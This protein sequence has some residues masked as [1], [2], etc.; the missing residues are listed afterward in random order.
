[1]RRLVVVLLALGMVLLLGPPSSARN[2]PK[3]LFLP[4]APVD[5]DSSFCGFPVHIDFPVDR[6]YGKSETLPDGT[7]VLHVN[8]RLVDVLSSPATTITRNASGPGVLYFAPD[9]TLTIVAHGLNIFPIT[10]EQQAET[11]LAGLV[12][13]SGL[14]ILRLNPDGSADLIRQ[15]GTVTSLCAQL[16]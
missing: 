6:E 2:D 12:Y 14:I 8:G 3:H 10:P 15:Q 16:A 13:T 5:L 9:G 1:M 7:T 4:A 11:G